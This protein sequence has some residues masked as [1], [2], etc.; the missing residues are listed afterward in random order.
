MMRDLPLRKGVGGSGGPLGLYGCIEARSFSS[1]SD[2]SDLLV[3]A[4]PQNS[5]AASPNANLLSEAEV[6]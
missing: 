2:L 6:L 1:E 4:R 3:R 5:R